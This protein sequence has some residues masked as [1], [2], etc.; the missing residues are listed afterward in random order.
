[1]VV[2]K[3]QE[4]KTTLSSCEKRILY[5]SIVGRLYLPDKNK[6]TTLIPSRK[7]E[8]SYKKKEERK[9]PCYENKQWKFPLTKK[10]SNDFFKKKKKFQIR[11]KKSF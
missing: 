11:K 8:V 3:E 5:L 2:W 1:M 6:Q 9:L 7:E 4:L 10:K